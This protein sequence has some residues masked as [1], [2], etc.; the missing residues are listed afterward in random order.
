MFDKGEMTV[1]ILPNRSIQGGYTVWTKNEHE[2]VR[3]WIFDGPL[4]ACRVIAAAFV[5]VGYHCK[6]A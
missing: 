2:V 4:P 1:M 3:R 6:N 5:E